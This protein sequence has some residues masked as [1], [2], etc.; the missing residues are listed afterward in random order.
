[1]KRRVTLDLPI[2]TAEEAET[3]ARFYGDNGLHSF[4]MNWVVNTVHERIQV[5]GAAIA[6][7]TT[8]LAWANSVPR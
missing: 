2:Q 6:V 3:L 1:M 7:N 4:L 8:L 5:V